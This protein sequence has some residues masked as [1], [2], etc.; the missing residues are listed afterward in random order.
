MQT[1]ETNKIKTKNLIILI[2]QYVFIGLGDMVDI[3][4]IN[5]SGVDSICVLSAYMVIIWCSVKITGIGKYAYRVYMKYKSECII[6]S[7]LS[8]LIVT[9]IFIFLNESITR[10][11]SLTDTQYEH[12]E[13]VLVIAG[14]MCVFRTLG[15]F[16]YEYLILKEKHKLAFTLNIVFYAVLIGTDAF[17]YFTT[18]VIEH[19]YLATL[20]SYL[21]WF[22]LLLIFTDFFKE[23]YRPNMLKLKKCAKSGFDIVIEGSVGKIATLVYNIYASKLGTELYAIHAVCYSVCVFCENYSYPFRIHTI[24][25]LS[26]E[27][28]NDAYDNMKNIIKKQSWIGIILTLVS[29]PIYLIFVKG[30]LD[31]AICLYF[32]II[33]TSDILPMIYFDILCGYATVCRKTEFLKKSSLVGVLVRIPAVVILFYGGCGIYALALPCFL[34]FFARMCYMHIKINNTRKNECFVR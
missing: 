16:G 34:D 17:V 27:D 25:Q 24:T 23:L 8:S 32:A 22:V 6:L 2:I 13:N 21:V 26:K 3:A 7:V 11:Y 30:S 28:K 1:Q 33:Y 20:F 12:F 9:F 5:A 4:F 29:I 31:Y 18:K 14:S 19:Y 10:M 15:D